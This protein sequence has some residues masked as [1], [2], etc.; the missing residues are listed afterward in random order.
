M[1]DSSN[2]GNVLNK[3]MKYLGRNRM[4]QTFLRFVSSSVD[5]RRL[6]T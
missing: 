4:G 1:S 3:F 6:K 5:K 2:Q